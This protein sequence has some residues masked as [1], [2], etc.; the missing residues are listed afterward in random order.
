MSNCKPVSTPLVAHFKLSSAS[1][2]QTEEEKEKMASIPYVGVVKWIFRYLKG[3]VDE[4]LI[5]DKNLT[6]TTNVVG[7]VDSDYGGDLDRRRVCRRTEGIKEA[8]WLRG[9]VMDLGIP[10]GVTVVYCDSQSAIFLTKN[11]AYHFKTKHIAVKYYY[12]SG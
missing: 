7:F 9:L 6:T 2:P 5:I 11:D 4:G 10:Q 1:C 3:T 8:G 12:V